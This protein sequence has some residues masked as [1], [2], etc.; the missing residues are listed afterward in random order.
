MKHYTSRLSRFFVTGM[1]TLA[2]FSL[3]SCSDLIG[4]TNSNNVSVI[5]SPTT[6]ELYIFNLLNHRVIE[7][8]ETGARP[9][10]LAVSSDS[11]RILVSNINDGSISVFERLTGVDFVGRGKINVQGTTPQGVAFNNDGRRA[12]VSVGDTS[13][14]AVLDT[15]IPSR[16]PNLV[17]SI[18]I[19]FNNTSA[20]R[21]S[22]AQLAVSPDGT[23]LFV[24]D[25]ANGALLAFNQNQVDNFAIGEVFRPDPNARVEFRDV[26]VDRSGR[27]YL[28]D[29]ANDQLLVF[30][31]GNIQQPVAQVTL[32]DANFPVVTPENIAINSSGTRLYITG[33]A[34]NV[35]SVINQ[36]SQLS[37]NLQIQQAGG[38]IPINTDASRPATSPVGIDITSNDGQIYVTNGGGGFNISLLESQ[39][40]QVR[41][42]RNIGTAASAANAPPL[43][44][45]KIVTF[46][47]LTGQSVPRIQSEDASDASA[48]TPASELSRL[49]F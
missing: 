32:K 30:N 16:L 40:Q 8:L 21:P 27:V 24:V 22:P 39:G 49:P 11:R 19:P 31:G 36:P 29:S 18:R 25:R 23:R 43:G 14:I 28:I 20:N 3:T 2:S 7:K 17:R 35:V 38:N 42:V 15:S 6:N 41:P 13:S 37:G 34:A 10:D 9:D 33:S 26:F 4:N 44:R 47:S 48:D 1:L 45:M 12:Y 5:V 46:N